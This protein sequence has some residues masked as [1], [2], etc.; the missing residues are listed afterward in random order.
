MSGCST[1]TLTAGLRWS[2]AGVAVWPVMGWLLRCNA[3]AMLCKRFS[4][5]TSSGATPYTSTTRVLYTFE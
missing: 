4:C 1:L 5:F 2:W 3:A